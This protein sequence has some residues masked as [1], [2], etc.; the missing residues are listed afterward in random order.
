MAN[1]SNYSLKELL[2]LKKLYPGV[3]QTTPKTI[4]IG[5]YGFTLL[6]TKNRAKHR[7]VKMD[8]QQQWT[9]VH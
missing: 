7:V 1:E 9:Q 3:F 5:S 8:K 4:Q 2:L 6:L